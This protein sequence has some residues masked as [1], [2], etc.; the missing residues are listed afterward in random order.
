MT[1]NRRDFL[2]QSLIVGAALDQAFVSA[3][4]AR[5]Q[6]AGAPA[7]LFDIEKLAEDVYAATA[8]PVALLN[9]NASIFVNAKDIL[10]VDAH[11]K[12]S[13]AAALVAQIRSEVN[14]K[15]VRYIVNTHFHWDHTQGMPHYRSAAP[16]ADVLA[17][18]ATRRSIASNAVER[19]KASMDSTRA[20]LEQLKSSHHKTPPDAPI[21]LALS[22]KWK[23]ICW[24]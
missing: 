6:S 16:N 24:R 15:P 21:G 2:T 10:V 23:A 13:A 11:S 22:R 17:S 9:C 8:K 19:L 1:I 14:P 18:S 3:G 20:D 7:T 4:K 5:A 12:P